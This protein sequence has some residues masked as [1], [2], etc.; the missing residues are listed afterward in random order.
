MN[1]IIIRALLFGKK[2]IN[3]IGTEYIKSANSFH[4]RHLK[5]TITAIKDQLP[6][7]AYDFGDVCKERALILPAASAFWQT[8]NTQK[9]TV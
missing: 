1:I 8:Y 6:P 9:W 5:I 2:P 7:W 4:I 3:V